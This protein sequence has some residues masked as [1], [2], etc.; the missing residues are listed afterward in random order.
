MLQGCSITLSQ[1]YD[2]NYDLEM[3]LYEYNLHLS[4]KRKSDEEYYIKNNIKFAFQCIKLIGK[5]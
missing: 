4:I 3:M 2:L 5:I 1:N